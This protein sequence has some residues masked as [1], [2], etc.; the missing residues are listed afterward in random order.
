MIKTKTDIEQTLS[1]IKSKYRLPYNIS[2][3]GFSSFTN[4]ARPHLLARAKNQLTP[5]LRH[6]IH[7]DILD[8]ISFSHCFVEKPHIF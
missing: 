2:S 4:Q 1:F 3:P 5:I 7:F 6:F 8:R